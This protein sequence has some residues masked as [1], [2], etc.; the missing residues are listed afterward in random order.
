VVLEPPG[1][2]AMVNNQYSQQ[3][4]L[5]FRRYDSPRINVDIVGYNLPQIFGI[6]RVLSERE[7]LPLL[8]NTVPSTLIPGSFIAPCK[9]RSSFDEIVASI[10]KRA[11]DHQ[12]LEALRSERSLLRSE[13]KRPWAF[14]TRKPFRGHIDRTT[15]TFREKI[16]LAEKVVNE[17]RPAWKQPSGGGKPI[18]YDIKKLS[19]TILIK[20]GL[21][22]EKLASELKNIGYDATLNGSGRSPCASYLH[23]VVDRK[24]PIEWLNKILDK[25]LLPIQRIHQFCI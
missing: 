16:M 2:D 17:M 3:S 11:A 14:K 4:I 25:E 18:E 10:S 7:A 20:G 22:F 5:E 6:N 15:P 23:Y 1:W 13:K 21:S 24:I 19:A 12:V 9:L 8:N